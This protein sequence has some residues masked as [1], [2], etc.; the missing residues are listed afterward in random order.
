MSL[1]LNNQ[2]EY[3][4]HIRFM[5]STSSW[6]KSGPD[7]MQ[8]FNFTKAV[9]DLEKIMTGYGYI[10]EGEAPEWV[11]DVNLTTPA[12]KP[13]DGREWKRGFKVE[14]FSTEMFGEEN[15]VMEFATTGTGAV[16]GISALYDAYEV[17]K[18]SNPGKLPVVS[19]NGG[20]A[21]KIGKGNTSV[22]TLSIIEWVD[23]PNALGGSSVVEQNQVSNTSSF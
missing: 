13:Q 9:F 16:M 8:N 23:R 19:F 12:Q 17:G 15:P 14:L 11:M 3:T 1:N 4:P 21:T 10:G 7:G 18:A 2:G 20:V 6:K 22:P 5:A